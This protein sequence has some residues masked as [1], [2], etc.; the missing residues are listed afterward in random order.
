MAR[1][2]QLSTHVCTSCGSQVRPR[3]I[4]PGTMG[5]ELLLW[6]CFLVPGIIYSIWR[7]ASGYNG[8]PVCKNRNLVPIGTPA[9]QSILRAQSG[10]PDDRSSSSGWKSIPS[11][12]A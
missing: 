5:M 3:S 4:T 1:K 8:C 6:L 7:I 10:A 2:P 9:A 11:P 12:T